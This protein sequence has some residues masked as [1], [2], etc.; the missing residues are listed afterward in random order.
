MPIACRHHK[1]LHGYG[2]HKRKRQRQRQSKKL[3]D[4]MIIED[5]IFFLIYQV[6]EVSEYASL[7]LFLVQSVFLS[8]QSEDT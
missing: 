6:E 7:P 4:H 5:Y 8:L 3:L 1:S 2:D